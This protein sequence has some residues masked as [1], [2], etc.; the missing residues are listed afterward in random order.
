MARNL[1][2]F[3][4]YAVFIALL[5]FAVV[6]T[7][8]LLDTLFSLTP[9]RG[10]YRTVPSQAEVVQAVVFAVVAWVIAGALGGLHYWLI[11]R[12]TRQDPAAGTSA[13]RSFFLNVAEG[14]GVSIAVPL[15][16]FAIRSWAHDYGVDIA[17]SA[18]V[19]LAVLLMVLLLE[20]ERRRVPVQ[21]GV[22]LAFQ[23]LHFFG[24]Q[25]FLLF[26]L[27]NVFLG[28]L[29][30]LIATVFSSIRGDTT[31]C[32]RF[33]TFDI[34]AAGLAA[35]ILW[36]IACWLFYSWITSK[37][38]SRLVRMILHGASF[39]FG[40]GWLLNGV[41][42]GI[43]LLLLPAFSIPVALRDVLG[44]GAEYDFFSPLLLGLLSAGVYHFLLTDVA[45]RRLLEPQIERLTEWAIAAVLLAATFWWGCGYGLYNILQAGDPVPA[46]PDRLAWV[47]TISMI[48][49]GLAYIAV[50][51]YLGLRNAREPAQANGPRRGFVLAL[52][53]GGIL[54]GA[55]GGATALYAWGTT[56]LGSPVRDWQQLTHAGLAAF[57]VGIVITALYLWVAL[58]ARLLAPREKK[59]SPTAPAAIPSPSIQPQPATIEATLDALL[60]GQ[61]SRDEA[62][63]RIR[64]LNL[65]TSEAPVKKDDAVLAEEKKASDV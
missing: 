34:N 53:A 48:V 15:I 55:I 36:F 56:L 46:A 31:W 3:Y 28:D 47:V 45:R 52:L 1:Y 64:A 21:A 30:R 62:A 2:R 25:I 44:G 61:I 16:G 7:S 60:T 39:A 42:I 32:G 63:E 4:L 24:V 22:A 8:R 58:R 59:A 38:S 49:T 10:T 33:C 57:F 14:V 18:S 19:A 54:S 50:D 9:L 41:F 40:V 65:S 12:D 43:K 29:R 35:S 37:D 13:I 5:I 17:G 51:I 23:R 20:L 27:T 26:F 11:R 6:A